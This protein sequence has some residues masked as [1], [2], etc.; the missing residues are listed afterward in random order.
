MSR[1]T[2]QATLASP[3]HGRLTH[4]VELAFGHGLQLN[5]LTTALAAA[6]TSIYIIYASFD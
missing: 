3:E 5:R 2:V 4:D 6:T 1:T